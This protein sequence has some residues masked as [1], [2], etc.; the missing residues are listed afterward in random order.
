MIFIVKI[1]AHNYILPVRSCELDCCIHIYLFV[2][3]HPLTFIRDV[4]IN[5]LFKKQPII[6]QPFS[7]LMILLSIMVSRF[8]WLVVQQVSL[9]LIVI[10]TAPYCCYLHHAYIGG[11]E[12]PQVGYLFYIFHLRPLVMSFSGSFVSYTTDQC[13]Y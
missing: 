2:Y 8:Y 7:I 5:T 10:L 6:S 3:F 13:R 4:L 9:L 12:P 11:I 1:T